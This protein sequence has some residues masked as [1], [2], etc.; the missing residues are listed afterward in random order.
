[1][2]SRRLGEKIIHRDYGA[3]KGVKNL[4]TSSDVTTPE[5]RPCLP[6]QESGKPLKTHP[7]IS[8]F[9]EFLSNQ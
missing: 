8:S 5:K 2:Y 6:K 9:P 4:L 7:F 3:G 1:V